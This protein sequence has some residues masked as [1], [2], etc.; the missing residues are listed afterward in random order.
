MPSSRERADERWRM[1]SD[2]HMDQRHFWTIDDFDAVLQPPRPVKESAMSE[3][4]RENADLRA[5]LAESQTDKKFS[6]LL[7]EFRTSQAQ[8]I[9]KIDALTLLSTEAKNAAEEAKRSSQLT[10]WNTVF[11]VLGLFAA[12]IALAAFGAQ[13]LATGK[14]LFEMGSAVKGG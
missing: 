9:G 2:P 8:I 4:D 11:L 12:V 6:D 5:K 1:P 3:S 10:R 13:A 14:E 7:G